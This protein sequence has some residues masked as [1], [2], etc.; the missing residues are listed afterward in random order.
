MRACC[1]HGNSAQAGSRVSAAM[2]V[3]DLQGCRSATEEVGDAGESVSIQIK[4]LKLP[5]SSPGRAED[6]FLANTTRME[7]H[8]SKTEDEQL[9][10]SREEAQKHTILRLLVIGAGS[11]G[12]AYAAAVTSSSTLAVIASVA[13]PVEFKR[14]VFGAKYIWQSG[15]RQD[16]QE[17]DSWQSFLSYETKRR[18]RARAG[19]DVLPGLDGVFVCTLDQTHVEIITALAPLGMH[20]MSEKPLATT[21]ADCLTIY[22]SL[23]PPDQEHPATIFSIG[24]VLRYSP[25]NM[26]LKKL[27]VDQEMIGD[28]ISIEHTEPVGWWHFSHSYVRYASHAVAN[29]IADVRK[30]QLA[31]GVR[32]GTISVD[33]IVS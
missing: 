13:E 7:G 2:R 3:V 32:H 24:H 1:S 22:R 29:M 25:H 11:R 20:I 15:H 31:Q 5:N 6:K 10:N 27:L 16:D 12:N 18:E 30:R 19:E 8:V 28:V 17:F 9:A 26:L 14:K 4:A 23:N 33:Q 21:L